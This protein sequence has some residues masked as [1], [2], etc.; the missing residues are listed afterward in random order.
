VELKLSVI[1]VEIGDDN[2]SVEISVTILGLCVDMDNKVVLC[3]KV[4]ENVGDRDALSTDETGISVV[5]NV[6]GGFDEEKDEMSNVVSVVFC[7]ND[8]E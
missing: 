5:E 8:V 7:D 4:F 1:A 3:L 2:P 6:T